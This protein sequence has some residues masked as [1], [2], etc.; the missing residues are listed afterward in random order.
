MQGSLLNMK[1]LPSAFRS[2]EDIEK[3]VALI[4]TYLV[5]LGGKHIQFN[6]VDKAILLDAQ[7]N[8]EKYLSLVVRVAGYSAL[9]IEL[10]RVVQDEIIART[11]HMS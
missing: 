8:P 2:K 5:T 9:W 6:V 3:L 7:A 1:F 4:K 11:E 10:N